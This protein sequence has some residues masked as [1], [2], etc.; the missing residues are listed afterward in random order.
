[1]SRPLE[2]EDSLGAGG[3]QRA[4]AIRDLAALGGNVGIRVPR[5]AGGPEFFGWGRP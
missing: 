2:S 5:C 1:M 3:I 4:Y